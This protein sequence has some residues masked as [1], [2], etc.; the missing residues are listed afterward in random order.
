MNPIPTP[1]AATLERLYQ[2]LFDLELRIARRADQLAQ[3]TGAIRSRNLE[4]WLRAELE[5]F[6]ELQRAE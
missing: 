5:V 2:V 3:A 4:C 1:G 6:S